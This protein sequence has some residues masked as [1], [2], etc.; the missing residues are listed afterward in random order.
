[1]KYLYKFVFDTGKLFFIS[2]RTK[3]SAIN[4]YCEEYGVSKEWVDNHCRVLNMGAE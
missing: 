3:K 1:M 2:A 4:K